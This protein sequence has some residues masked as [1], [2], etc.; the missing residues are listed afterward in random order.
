LST[1]AGFVSAGLG[2]AL[3]PPSKGLKLP[4]MIWIPIQNPDCRCEV[5]LE[6]KEKRYFSPAVKLFRDFAIDYY[7]KKEVEAL[8]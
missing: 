8:P 3:L 5:G 6:W 1:V 7:Q 4:N 2:V